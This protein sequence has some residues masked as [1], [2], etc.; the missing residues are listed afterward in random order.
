ELMMKTSPLDRPPESPAAAFCPRLLSEHQPVGLAPMGAS[1]RLKRTTP[2]TSEHLAQGWVESSPS[3]R[4]AAVVL[5]VPGG[6]APDPRGGSARRLQGDGTPFHLVE[7]PA[8]PAVGD[9]GRDDAR[10]L[11]P[12]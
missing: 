8:D 3:A 4:D 1:R 2:S 10:R 11:A 7:Q 6:L 12:G 5:P 9:R